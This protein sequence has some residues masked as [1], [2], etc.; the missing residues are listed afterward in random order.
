LGLQSRNL[1]KAVDFD[2]PTDEPERY[3]IQVNRIIRDTKLATEIKELYNYI[4][5]LCGYCIEF[6]DGRRYAEAHHVK[7]L[8]SP[9]NG[10]DSQD[11]ILCLCP[12]CHAKLDFGIIKLDSKKINSD[13][14][15]HAIKTEY[16][17]YHNTH[18]FR[19]L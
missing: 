12:N 1:G 6:E 17:E 18:I 14:Q 2:V 16:I 5:Q 9:H 11:N 13:D 15:H 3:A 10:H 7:P 19:K 8:G 4:C